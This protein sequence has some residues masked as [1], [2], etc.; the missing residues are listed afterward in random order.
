LEYSLFKDSTH[1]TVTML[2]RSLCLLLATV[3]VS[4]LAVPATRSERKC[5]PLKWES[6]V[7]GSVAVVVQGKV[8]ISE[9]IASTSVD[10]SKNRV[11]LRQSV[12]TDGKFSGN[13]TVLSI[14]VST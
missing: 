7:Y 1:S 2:A 11:S 4:A 3:A 6:S 12:Y 9:V 8:T 10:S 14:N 5:V 13:Y